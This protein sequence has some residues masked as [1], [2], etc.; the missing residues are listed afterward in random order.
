MSLQ[1]QGEADES[2][3]LIET[4][5]QA[6]LLELGP[7]NELTRMAEKARASGGDPSAGAAQGVD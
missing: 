4:S 6:L 5:Y 3:T 1:Q 7:E 2:V